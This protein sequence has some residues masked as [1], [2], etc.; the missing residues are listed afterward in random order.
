MSQPSANFTDLF[1]EIVTEKVVVSKGDILLMVMK[2]A[3]KTN[4]SLTALANLIEMI[5]LM[6]ERPILPHSQYMFS[7]L[8]S[9]VGAKMT[10]H[11][12][13]PKC[14]VHAG[15]SQS[16][17]SLQCPKCGHAMEVSAMADAPFFVLLDIPSQVQKLIKDCNILDLTKPLRPCDTFSDITDGKLY[18]DFVTSTIGSGNRISF[19]LNTDGTP[20]FKSSGT[21]IWPVQLIIN[22]VPPEQR[23]NKLVL[24]AL[25]F[26]KEKPNME[27]FQG[28]F[29]DAL[30]KLG[31]EGFLLEH[32]GEE[33]V[34]KAFC[35]CCAVDSVARAPMQG[36]MQFNGYYGCNWCLQQGERI[37][38]T[39]KYPVQQNEPVERTEKQMLR[40]METALKDGSP[41]HGVKTVSPLINLQ[42]FNIVSGFVPDYMHCILLG[43]GRQFLDL[44]LDE[45]GR[46]FY[47]G[48]HLKI[49]N[50][51]LLSLAPPREVKRMPRSLKERKWWKAKEL[52]N[53]I[54]FY[55]LPVLEGIL[56]KKYLQHWACLVESLHLLL[57]K[58]LHTCDLIIAE[59]YLLEF[60]IKAEILYGKE[61]MTFNMHQVTHLAKSVHQW[62]PLWSHSA[63]PFESGNGSLKAIVKA[64]NGIPHQICRSLQMQSAVHELTKLTE[65]PQILSYCS[66]FD[67][68]VTQKAVSVSGDIHFFG[69]GAPYAQRDISVQNREKL[70][71]H[72]QEFSRVLKKKTILTNKKYAENKKTNSSCVQ[73]SSGSYAIIEHVLCDNNSRAYA[74][75]TRLKCSPLRYMTTTMRH[76]LKV[77]GQATRM[78]LIELAEVC[79]VCVF[80]ELEETYVS[81]VPSSFTL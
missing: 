66:S 3:L 62:G 28:A 40:D 31:E 37:A 71:G 23:M 59:K 19:T 79:K 63:F 80:I 77:V 68:T 53:W 15:H 20:L 26:G 64:T 69:R 49:I 70:S 61:S 32:E 33:K 48:R 9:N 36:I 60:H 10:F 2:Y 4:L 17:T 8:C 52:E 11:F 27:L 44:W 75:V 78:E 58:D 29:V 76:L 42:Q 1:K 13:C 21:A 12:F 22:E 6:F 57:E 55:S 39:L 67:K 51:R 56:A 30:N 54:L 81:P 73:L 65:A 35:I 25:W 16:N 41:V 43:L 38:G 47:I 45:T 50:Q 46:D 24:A 14:Y 18:R 34:F 7:K 72:V 5:N 74:I